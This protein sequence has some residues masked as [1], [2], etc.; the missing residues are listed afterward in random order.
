MLAGVRLVITVSFLQLVDIHFSSL[1]FTAEAEEENECGRGD[2]RS[3]EYQSLCHILWRVSVGTCSKGIFDQNPDKVYKVDI[4]PEQA[5]RALG[6]SRNL[7]T[8]F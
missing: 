8:K 3:V 2:G 7:C 4:E 5:T 1:L 6:I